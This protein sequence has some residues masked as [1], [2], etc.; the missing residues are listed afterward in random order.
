[1]TAWPGTLFSSEGVKGRPAGRP[2]YELWLDAISRANQPLSEQMD[3]NIGSMGFFGKK[4]IVFDQF[5][6][7]EAK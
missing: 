2:F 1:M 4:V 3:P 7:N 5:S 6:P